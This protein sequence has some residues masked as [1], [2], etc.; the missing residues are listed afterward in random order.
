MN[1]QEYDALEEIM[2]KAEASEGKVNKTNVVR[3]YTRGRLLIKDPA[4]KAAMERQRNP[5]Q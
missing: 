4:L 2:K 5:Y 1:D 3:V